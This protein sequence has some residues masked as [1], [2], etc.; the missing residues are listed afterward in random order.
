LFIK[1][2]IFDVL[3]VLNLHY[4]KYLYL[5]RR[6]VKGMDRLY[7][8]EDNAKY[9]LLKELSLDKTNSQNLTS[10]LI[11]GMEGKVMLADDC[12]TIGG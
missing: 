8:Q 6:N 12:V 3:F 4:S 9:G 7:I 2:L 1:L 11:D 10:V 5:G